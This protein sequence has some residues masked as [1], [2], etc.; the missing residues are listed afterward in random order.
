MKFDQ[1]KIAYT[2]HEIPPPFAHEYDLDIKFQ[3][4][5]LQIDYQLRYIL[6]DEISPDE[7]EAEGFSANDDFQWKGV[8]HKNWIQPIQEV[9]DR[10]NWSANEELSE[11]TQQI[12]TIDVKFKGKE[13]QVSLY[14]NQR[15]DQSL[16]EILQAIYETAGIEPPLSIKL[17]LKKGSEKKDY[18]FLAHFKNRTVNMEVN[19]NARLMEW[20]QGKKF[21]QLVFE[22]DY[23]LPPEK[24]KKDGLYI[25]FLDD[26]WYHFD[27]VTKEEQ[28]D[29][30]VEKV[31]NFLP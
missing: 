11:F 10:I 15:L 19:G 29:G 20:E 23:L 12:H 4:D 24:I 31:L 14:D 26:Q 17:S 28:L 27:K 21:M 8:L 18:T 9:L 16:Q 30:L 22:P 5:K 7:I 25:S 6:R 13:S 1:I 2:T 3:P